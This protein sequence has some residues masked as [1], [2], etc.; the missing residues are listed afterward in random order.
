M[1]CMSACLTQTYSHMI[2]SSKHNKTYH[3]QKHAHSK[4]TIYPCHNIVATTITL[5]PQ[6]GATEQ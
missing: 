6:L 4:L 3:L 2:F 5:Y 1:Q